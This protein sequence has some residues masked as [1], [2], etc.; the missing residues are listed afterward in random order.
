MLQYF[1]HSQIDFTKYNDIVSNSLSPIVYA[2]KW[3]LDLSAKSGWDLLVYNDYE[4]LMP[5]PKA[6]LKSSFWKNSIVQPYFAQQ[7]GLL[8]KNKIPDEIQLEFLQYLKSLKPFLY[9]FNHSQTAAY[10]DLNLYFRKNYILDLQQN[11]DEIFAGFSKSKR[12]SV[13]KS[14]K[15]GIVVS[16]EFDIQQFIDFQH[17][18]SNF[19]TSKKIIAQKSNILNYCLKNKL[20]KM[21]FTRH[22]ETLIGIAFFIEYRNRIYYV[23]AASNEEGRKL[24]AT[25]F[26]L[27]HII[28]IHAGTNKILD[29]EGSEIPGVAS[30]MESFGAINQPFPIIKS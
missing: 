14:K 10:E 25:D 21:F 9:H 16:E 2:E 28:E 8:S 4:A 11:Y 22:N 20:G 6:R 5:I 15:N 17:R 27:N 13:R 24:L 3:F 29:F 19:K 26:I 18:N 23:H 7:L 1:T 12:Q 30:F